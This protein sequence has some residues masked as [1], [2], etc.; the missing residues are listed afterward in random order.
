MRHLILL[1]AALA[2]L[3]GCASVKGLPG[4][5][6]VA[7]LKTG[8]VGVVAQAPAP[9]GLDP[10]AAAAFWG[11]RYD[12]NPRDP[13]TA[14]R[15]SAAL[16]AVQNDEE[17]LRVIGQAAARGDGDPR[18]KLE[19][20]KALIANER[21]HEAVRPA[22]QAI[23]GGLHEDWSAYSTYGVAL[24]KTGQHRKARVQYDRALA[25]SADN[26]RVL[27]N[28]GLSYALSGQPGKAESTLRTAA[29]L[30]GGSAHVRQNLALVLGLSG[31]TAEAEML[32]RSDLPPMVAS[33]NVAYF[34]SLVAQPAYWGRLDRADAELPDFGDEPLPALEAAPGAAPA[35]APTPRPAPRDEVAPAEPVRGRPAPGVLSMNAGRSAALTA[36][37]GG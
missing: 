18:V 34:Q 27:N 4:A 12:A 29:A 36:L 2:V 17:A 6:H 25:L 15:F 14:V 16:R 7:G 13:E 33:G 30:P 10:I 11:T 5:A 24:D 19:L 31:R 37:Q 35:A 21:A 23:A 20:A 8:D 28:K 3:P 1:G 22:E 26:A 9:G 32:A